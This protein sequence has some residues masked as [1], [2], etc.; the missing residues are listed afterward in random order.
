MKTR[1][2]HSKERDSNI[3]VKL[4][5]REDSQKGETIIRDVWIS[6]TVSIRLN[7]S[8]VALGAVPRCGSAHSERERKCVARKISSKRNVHLRFAKSAEH[9]ICALN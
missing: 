3:K 2:K 8:N 7:F 6:H 9:H 4:G 1:Q 5:H